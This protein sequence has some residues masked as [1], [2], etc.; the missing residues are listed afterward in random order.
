MTTVRA[1][2][3]QSIESWQVLASLIA[4]MAFSIEEA[5]AIA[6]GTTDGA[7]QLV[8]NPT[9]YTIAGLRYS[10]AATDDLWDLSGETDTAAATFRAYWLYLNAAGAA[11]FAAG[12]D[13]I[14][15]A[16]AI[17]ALP[18]PDSTKSILGVYVAGA[19][20]DFDG[21]AGLEAQ[22]DV[23]DGIPAGANL[24][25]INTYVAPAHVSLVR[26]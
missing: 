12:T 5:G 18:D 7:L 1:T 9:G 16:A 2:P 11:S 6:D 15:A 4:K 25:G 14:S 26:A 10:K 3:D 19:A 17:G 8:T 22:G 20:T 24:G 13:S 21:A 23:Y